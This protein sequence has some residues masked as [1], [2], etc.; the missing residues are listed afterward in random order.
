MAST[1]PIMSTYAA[2]PVAGVGGEPA[3]TGALP[4]F[5]EGYSWSYSLPCLLPFFSLNVDVSWVSLHVGC[6]CASGT[7][8]SVFIITCPSESPLD[9]S[10]DWSIYIMQLGMFRS[11][12]PPHLETACASQNVWYSIP[13]SP[14]WEAVN[15]LL[16]GLSQWAP[17]GPLM[18]FHTGNVT[19]GHWFSAF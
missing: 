15:S 5:S 2:D 19:G 12:I 9:V 3:D 7:L 8:C 16:P 17:Q 6:H 1:G 14:L 11:E 10:P 13:T 18:S 4:L